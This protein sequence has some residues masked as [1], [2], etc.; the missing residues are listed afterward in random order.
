MTHDTVAVTANIRAQTVQSL[1]TSI[2][3]GSM[4]YLY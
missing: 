1:Q 3:A 4:V 2:T